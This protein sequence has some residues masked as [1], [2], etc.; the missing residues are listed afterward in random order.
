MYCWSLLLLLLGQCSSNQVETE[1]IYFSMGTNRK[2][3]TFIQI[4]V[5]Y[6]SIVN[7]E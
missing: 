7:Q 3:I 6:T 2:S 5:R 1:S 4:L